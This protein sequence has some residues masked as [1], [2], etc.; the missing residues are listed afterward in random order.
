MFSGV[1]GGLDPALNIGDIVVADRAVQ[2]DAGVIEADGLQLYQA[3]HVPF[4]NPTENLGYRVDPELDARVRDRLDGFPLPPVSRAAGG[5]DRP[6][7]IAHGAVLTGDQ[8]LHDEPTRERL[9]AELGGCAVDMEGAAVAQ[10]CEAF[11]APWLL[12]RALS[13]LAGRDSRFDFAAFVDE[14]AASSAAILRHLLPVL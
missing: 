9:H 5:A 4:I 13:D 1:A 3:G 8:F 2:H 7:R 10:V 12:I 14:V 6:P 11:G